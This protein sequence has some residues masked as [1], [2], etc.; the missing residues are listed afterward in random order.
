MRAKLA[1][2]FKLKGCPICNIKAQAGIKYIRSVIYEFANDPF[3][4][5]KLRENIGFCSRHSWM[6][7]KPIEKNIITDRLGAVVITLDVLEKYIEDKLL[8]E[9][10]KGTRGECPACRIEKDTENAFLQESYY[11]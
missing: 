6:I 2:L 5:K 4:R 7:I 8:I 9:N 11:G 10:I 1:S 3:L